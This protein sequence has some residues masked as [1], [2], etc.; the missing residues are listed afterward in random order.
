[1]HPRNNKEVCPVYYSKSVLVQV[2]TWRNKRHCRKALNFATSFATSYI[3]GGSYNELKNLLYI[4]TYT[5][6]HGM[7]YFIWWWWWWWVLR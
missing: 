1:M 3:E 5:V 6:T 4:Y 7:N 2:M